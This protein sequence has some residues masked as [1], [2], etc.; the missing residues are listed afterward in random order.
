MK[1]NNRMFKVWFQRLAYLS[2][3]LVVFALIGLPEAGAQSATVNYITQAKE[4][5]YAIKNF[6]FASGETL[7]ELRINY[8]TWGEP[9]TD[10]S[11]KITNA[12]LLCHGL[13]QSWQ[14]FG[15]P[16]W[17]GKL[18]GP[19][20]P[21]DLTKYFLVAPDNIGTGKSS[22]PSDGL[23]MQFPKYNHADTVKAQYLLLTEKLGINHL[24]AVI[25]VSYG[26]RLAW[27]WS[28]QYPEFM[29][30]VVS[31]IS[32]PFPYAGRNGM[33]DFLC[34]EILLTDPTWQNGNYT[35]QPRNL[36]LSGMAFMLFLDGA[37]HLWE[38]APTREKS[39]QYMSDAVRRGSGT[40]DANNW[41]YQLRAV[42]GYDVYSQLDRVKSRMLIINM[43]GDGST[44]V[45]LGLIEK[46]LEKLGEKAEYLLVKEAFGYGH[47][48]IAYTTDIYGPKI[49]EFLEKLEKSEKK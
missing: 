17:A 12:I 31:L 47:F 28:V 43:A 44:A 35:E 26:G 49:G 39:F 4:N 7:P 48:A 16:F 6:T 11:G 20:L 24:Q 36:P 23:R 37:G 19:G 5:S 2:C 40:L 15:Q 33:R 14:S 8:A 3:L 32:H 46:A 30:G 45:E 18:Y 25:G 42:D 21:L 10:P 29:S 1:I 34:L 27:Q 38:L 22:K 13:A 41:M 9:K